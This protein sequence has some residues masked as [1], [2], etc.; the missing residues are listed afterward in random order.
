[1]EIVM[2]HTMRESVNG[3]RTVQEFVK[4]SGYSVPDDIG[5]LWVGHG[6]ALAA[7]AARETSTV[8]RGTSGR[9]GGKR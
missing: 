7:A 1:M 3:G 4:G 5:Q 8:K 6:W 2:Q 9:D